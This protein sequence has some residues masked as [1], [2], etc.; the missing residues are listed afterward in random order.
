MHLLLREIRM[1]RLNAPDHA[2]ADVIEKFTP[3]HELLLD[4]LLPR[5][6]H[7]FTVEVLSKFEE[8]FHLPQVYPRRGVNGS[9]ETTVRSRQIK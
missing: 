5:T 4:R 7:L 6:M 3:Q 1:F 8:L 9:D 2:L